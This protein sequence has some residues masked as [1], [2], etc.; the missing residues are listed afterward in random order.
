[1]LSDLL[2]QFRLREGALFRPP[3]EPIGGLQ[4]HIDGAFLTL[5]QCA[6]LLQPAG[7]LCVCGRVKL[8]KAQVRQDML[9]MLRIRRFAVRD[10]DRQGWWE[11]NLVAQ[12]MP[13][14]G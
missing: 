12:V 2:P 9:A 8:L 6:V 13:N 10:F 11:I 5:A 1:L 14:V 3:Q 4:H 7:E